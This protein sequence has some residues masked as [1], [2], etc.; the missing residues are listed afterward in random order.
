MS[1]ERLFSTVS[2]TITRTKVVYNFIRRENGKL[3]ETPPVEIILESKVSKPKIQAQLQK[4][5]PSEVIQIVS[6]KET[7]FKASMPV[8]KFIELAD[9]EVIEPKPE[10]EA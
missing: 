7:Q 10:K 4:K 9:K 8:E 2:R 3:I 5:F 1:R 6:L